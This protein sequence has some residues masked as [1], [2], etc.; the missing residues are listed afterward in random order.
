MCLVPDSSGGAAGGGRQPRYE[1]LCGRIDPLPVELL[2]S[3]AD[4]GDQALLAFTSIS[5]HSYH[6]KK[7]KT[8]L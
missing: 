5:R 8:L 3:K 1:V 6:V 2:C 4:G 7:S